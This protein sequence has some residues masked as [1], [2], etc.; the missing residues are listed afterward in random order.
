MKK[1]ELQYNVLYSYTDENEKGS[2]KLVSEHVITFVLS[3]SIQFH[4]NQGVVEHHA[5][6]LG[7]LRKN[8]LL[9]SYKYPDSDGRPFQSFNV[10]IDQESLKNIALL[11]I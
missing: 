10:F 9:R 8:L 3:G 4:I 1:N 6:Q 7:L 2:E 5:G 11:I